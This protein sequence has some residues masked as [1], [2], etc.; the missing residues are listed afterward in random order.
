MNIDVVATNM[1]HNVVQLLPNLCPDSLPKFLKTT[2]NIIVF[3]PNVI[4]NSNI[5]LTDRLYTH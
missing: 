4:K 1:Y 2:R 3:V 5:K